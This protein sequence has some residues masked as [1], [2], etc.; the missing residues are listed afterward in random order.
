VGGQCIR[1][2]SP[3][4]HTSQGWCGINVLS[5]PYALVA[6]CSPVKSL[7]VACSVVRGEGTSLTINMGLRCGS[8]A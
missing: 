4:Q 8:D 2:V 3:G 6:G 5:Q 7:V 1:L